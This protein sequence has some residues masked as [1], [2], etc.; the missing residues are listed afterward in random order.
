MQNPAAEVAGSS[1]SHSHSHSYGSMGCASSLPLDL[2]GRSYS[3]PLLVFDTA[4]DN[5]QLL[6]LQQQQQQ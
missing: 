5:G 3:S 6:A 1:S 2:R 4:A